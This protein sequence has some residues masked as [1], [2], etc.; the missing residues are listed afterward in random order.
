MLFIQFLHQLLEFERER[1]FALVPMMALFLAVKT[2]AITVLTDLSCL[3]VGDPPIRNPSLY[4]LS[5]TSSL[6]SSRVGRKPV[7]A[8]LPL[9]WHP[10]EWGIQ[11]T[12]PFSCQLEPD[13]GII[14]PAWA[15]HLALRMSTGGS[16][17]VSVHH[18]L[19]VPAG[20][21][22]GLKVWCGAGPSGE[23]PLGGSQWEAPCKSSL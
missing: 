18:S 6:P 14:L 22:I 1:F 2:F 3:P 12:H 4:H 17:Y 15:V 8:L 5:K 7:Q 9:V 23:T 13:D 16:M 19:H 20:L 21:S 11:C 10:T